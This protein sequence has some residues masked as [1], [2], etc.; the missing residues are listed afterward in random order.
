MRFSEVEST[1]VGFGF[2]GNSDS[3]S[4]I[5]RELVRVNRSESISEFFAHFRSNKH[6]C[7]NCWINMDCHLHEFSGCHLRWHRKT[8]QPW[9]WEA[10]PLNR[11]RR[12]SQVGPNLFFGGGS[13]GSKDLG[14]VIADI[15]WVCAFV[16][17][18]LSW[19]WESGS[20][21]YSFIPFYSQYIHAC[22]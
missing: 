5:V 20:I 8:V 6:E 22:I 19:A 18:A 2:P 11:S 3:T 1:S 14:E 13:G 4:S 16:G 21:K 17:A 12:N 9:L 7:C 15:H 10:C